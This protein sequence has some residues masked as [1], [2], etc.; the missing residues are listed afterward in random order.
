MRDPGADVR[1]VIAAAIAILDRGIG[2]PMQP[3]K[4]QLLGADGKP[5]L[6][7]FHVIIAPYPPK[8]HLALQTRATEVL[9]GGAE[10][11]GVGAAVCNAVPR[12]LVEV[13][14]RHR[15]ARDGSAT[16]VAVAIFFA[17]DWNW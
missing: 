8:Q 10:G 13:F 5:I 7:N 4:Q 9:Y 11:G 6:P 3:T 14:G 15:R 16:A 2:K 17:V 1:A 12:F